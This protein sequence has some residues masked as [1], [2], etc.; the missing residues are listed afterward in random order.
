[1]KWRKNLRNGGGWKGDDFRWNGNSV[2]Y[3]GH[4]GYL[5]NSA[6]PDLPLPVEV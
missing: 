5:L 6:R 2:Y 4:K 1:M 3:N